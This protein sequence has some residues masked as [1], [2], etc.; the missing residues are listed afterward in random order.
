ML[1]NNAKTMTPNADV[2]INRV[3]R[4]VN[5]PGAGVADSSVRAGISFSPVHNPHA[6]IHRVGA[7]SPPAAGD[8]DRPVAGGV[9]SDSFRAGTGGVICPPVPVAI[10]GD[11]VTH[12]ASPFYR[13]PLRPNA[14]PELPAR[15]LIAALRNKAAL[16]D[17][18]VLLEFAGVFVAVDDD[19]AVVSDASFAPIYPMLCDGQRIRV[20]VLAREALDD[21]VCVL[22]EAGHRV[23]VAA[24]IEDPDASG[25]ARTAIV[26]IAS[27][28]ERREFDNT[29]EAGHAD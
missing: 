15:V 19:A 24:A 9:F 29:S 10:R 8:H 16:G 4:P 7:P 18:I 21:V 2:L 1:A 20:A 26:R 28:L 25:F 13:F 27:P 14:A 23:A 3:D 11:A 5:S 6:P 12:P 17:T 22:T